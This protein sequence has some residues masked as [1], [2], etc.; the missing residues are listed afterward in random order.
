MTDIDHDEDENEE[1]SELSEEDRTDLEEKFKKAYAKA[2]EKIDEQIEIAQK[3]ISK[4]EEISE[5]YGIPFHSQITPLSMTYRPESFSDK[6]GE[7]VDSL[8]ELTDG[9]M[10]GVPDYEG[11]EHSAVC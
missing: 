2:S 3:A 9:E 1:E 8:D 7:L 5:K 11:W 4:A 6:W 10:Y